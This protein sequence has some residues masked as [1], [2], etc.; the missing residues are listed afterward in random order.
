MGHRAE[1]MGQRAW[2]KEHGAKSIGHGGSAVYVERLRLRLEA[3]KDRYVKALCSLDDF[4]KI[5]E[6]VFFFMHQVG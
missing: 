6:Q 1:G 5:F 3:K 4:G 2:G